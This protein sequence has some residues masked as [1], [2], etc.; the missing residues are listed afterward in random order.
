MSEIEI[1]AKSIEEAIQLAMER[2]QAPR[3]AID[4]I[5]VDEVDDTLEGAEPL[6]VRIKVSRKKDYLV[7]LARDKVTG[8]LKHM[9]MLAE[10]RAELAG[11]VIKVN[12]ATKDG[13]ILIGR[14]GETL[15]ALQHIVNRMMNRGG[16]ELP[17]VL[18]DVENYRER[19]HARLEGEA[20]SAANKVVETGEEIVLEPMPAGDRKIIHN[21]LKSFEG[22]KTY[23]RGREGQRQVIV[24]LQQKEETDALEPSGNTD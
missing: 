11:N 1:T 9:D 13:S 7:Q 23:S 20:K 22:V 2:M 19:R 12:L 5:R 21:F 3:D 16:R 4:I 15:E 18:L 14:K 8:I 6:E 10:V 17:F 24:A